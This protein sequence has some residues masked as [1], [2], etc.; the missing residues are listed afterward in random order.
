MDSTAARGCRDRLIRPC[1]TLLHPIAKITHAV[2]ASVF[3]FSNQHTKLAG[4]M[5]YQANGPD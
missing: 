4:S 2:Q 3:S 5:L 1:M